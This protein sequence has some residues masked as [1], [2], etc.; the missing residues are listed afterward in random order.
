MK[1]HLRKWHYNGHTVTA[2]TKSEAR[3]RLKPL[4]KLP[5]GIPT[6]ALIVKGKEEKP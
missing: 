2:Y 3:A 1:H 5:A 4:L 6:G